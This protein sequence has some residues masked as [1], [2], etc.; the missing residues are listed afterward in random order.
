MRIRPS[1]S[2]GCS[3]CWTHNDPTSRTPNPNQPMTLHS[4]PRPLRWA[5]APTVAVGLLTAAGCSHPSPST[6]GAAPAPAANMSAS[7]PS[8][9]P[10]V[11]LHPGFFNA[12]EAIRNLQKVSSTPPSEK[13]FNASTPG[14]PRLWNSDLAFVGNYV[15]QGNFGG[16]QIW[17]ISNPSKPT[18]KTAY[19][20]PGSQSDVSV[21]HNL[22]VV[23]SEATNGRI[24]CGT[25]GV[26]D[27]VSK[28]RARGVRIYDITDMDHPK[29]VTVVQT[30]RGSHTNTLVTD[31]TDKDNVYIYVSG[32]GRRAVLRRAAGMRERRAGREHR[33]LPNRSDSN[34][35]S[36]PGASARCE[37]A[38]H[39]RE[40]DDRRGERAHAAGP[41]QRILGRLCCGCPT[42][43]P[44]GRRA[45][46]QRRADAPSAVQRR[47]AMSR[48]HGLSG[49]RVCWRGVRWVWIAS[50]H[51]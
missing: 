4:L 10:R 40:R 20:C 38:A 51:P 30:C 44:T 11:G 22:L 27:T 50:G 34:P 39:L 23:S 5:A 14:D 43:R 47:D 48:H 35:A 25:E 33:P 17:D 45:R 41:A 42:G 15:I 21:Y 26:Q 13:F 8:P 12:G 2:N 6:A 7:A 31:P 29:E 19:V 37:L 28:D 18:L 32:I 9:D 36:A 16:M 49:G 24:D 1:R 3:R 46:R